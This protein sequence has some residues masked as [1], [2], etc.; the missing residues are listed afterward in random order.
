MQINNK[1]KKT[2]NELKKTDVIMN[3]IQMKLTLSRDRKR[4][5]NK[6]T[7]DENGESKKTNTRIEMYVEVSY[8]ETSL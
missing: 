1:K 7:K 8:T 5:G 6:Q 3:V 2:T 4:V